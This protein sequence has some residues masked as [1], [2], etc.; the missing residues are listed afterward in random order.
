M[1]L[2]TDHMF[3]FS[4]GTWNFNV[5]TTLILVSFTFE[6]SSILQCRRLLPI[7]TTNK[8][9]MYLSIWN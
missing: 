6:K 3:I 1:F 8:N 9:I 5:S 2:I 4:T 7:A